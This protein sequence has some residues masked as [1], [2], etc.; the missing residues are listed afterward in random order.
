M[1]QRTTTFVKWKQ[2]TDFP[3]YYISNNGLIRKGT[4]L[5]NLK[6]NEKGKGYYFVSFRGKDEKNKNTFKRYDIHK[7][8]WEYFGDGSI[9]SYEFHIDHINED[10]KD[11]R[12][13][14]LRV[15]PQKKNALKSML[16]KGFITHERYSFLLKES[17]VING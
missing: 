6:T 7:L 14:N 15:I 1:T 16:A 8:V 10:T 9:S 3:N 4:V 17:E 13:E 5:Q 11:N 2:L 12:I